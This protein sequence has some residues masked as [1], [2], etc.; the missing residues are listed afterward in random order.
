MI[1]LGTHILLAGGE[2]A[3]VIRFVPSLSADPVYVVELEQ[4]RSNGTGVDVVLESECE[5]VKEMGR[6]A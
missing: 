5:V 4:R 3:T 6:V 2:R 1:H